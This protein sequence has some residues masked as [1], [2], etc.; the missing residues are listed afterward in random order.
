MQEA[1]K[2]KATT[3]RKK[4][5]MNCLSLLYFWCKQDM[6]EYKLYARLPNKLNVLWKTRQQTKTRQRI[7]KCYQ[8]HSPSNPWPDIL[9]KQMEDNVIYFSVGFKSYDIT[10]EESRREIWYNWT[11]R[12]CNMI[13]R[14][15]FSQ[16][17]IWK[18]QDSTEFFCSRKFNRYGHY[19]SIVTMQNKR[20][21][22]II[23][24]LTYRVY[25]LERQR[26][27]CS[28]QKL[29]EETNGLLE[30]WTRPQYRKEMES[31]VSL[32]GLALHKI[33]TTG[34]G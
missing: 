28:T 15:F 8:A 24:E 11:E 12:D 27:D 14:T 30:R 22:V 1:L 32:K 5:Q 13:R 20:R 3:F 23:P 6:N 26:K 19:I 16:K 33:I 18:H 9:A 2:T 34:L 21:S 25:S 31:S 17:T 7:E 10:R 29:P 4:N